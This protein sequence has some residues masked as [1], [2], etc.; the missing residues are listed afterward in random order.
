[1]WPPVSEGKTDKFLRQ[2][3]DASEIAEREAED[4]DSAEEEDESG[5]DEGKDQNDDEARQESEQPSSAKKQK[6]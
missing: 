3:L 2:F 6:V 4:C 1:M 5:E